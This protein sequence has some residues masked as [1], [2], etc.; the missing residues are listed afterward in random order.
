ML[1]AAEQYYQNSISRQLGTGSIVLLLL[2]GALGGWALVT[3]IAGAVLA[4]GVVIVESNVKKV[5]HPTGGIVGEFRV[6]DGST[7]KPGD[8]LIRLDETV[9]KANLAIVAKNLV[10][11]TARKARLEAERDEMTK[12]NFPRELLALRSD[13]ETTRTLESEQ[14]V[15]ELRLKARAGQKA[16]LRERSAQMQEEIEGHQAQQRGKAKELEFIK[17]E[18]KGARELWQKNLMPITKL[19][20]LEREGARLEG[21][22][23]QLMAAI[24]QGKGKLA[25]ID[26][27]ILQ[28]DRDAATDIG[29]E[30]REVEGRVGEF[31][32]RKV[33][34]ED[35]MRR[36]D[37]R[38][39]QA[40]TV[41]QSIVHTVGGV[42]SPGETLMLIVPES[43]NLALEAKV[44]PND[45]D[46]LSI[47]QPARLRFPAFSQRT[48][49][50]IS[51]KVSQISADI[52]TDQRTG[53]SY[54][55]VRIAWEPRELAKLG[56][57]KLV[58]GMPVEAMLKTVDRKVISYLIK[59][60]Q[61]Q[62]TRAFREK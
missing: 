28:I 36:I 54:Y 6:R 19:T 12:I 53:A 26:L 25:E 35:Q 5:Q 21:E 57:I 40:G 51:G 48:T 61:D 9:T 2:V 1:T 27:Q 32:E 23:A 33:A 4:S 62:L 60:L 30:L 52:T 3:D 45:I 41:L 34:A 29:K 20:S 46:Q 24:A 13:P 43:D 37:I 15:F 10:E 18:L 16:L 56:E 50:E 59:P 22:R 8:V 39:P 47:G 17:I 7:V 44:S 11:L 38:A 14:K 49:P 42:I 55:T 31:I 58:P